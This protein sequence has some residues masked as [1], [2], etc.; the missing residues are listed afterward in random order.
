MTTSLS[1]LHVAVAVSFSSFLACSSFAQEGGIETVQDIVNQ[2]GVQGGL[3]VEVGAA[4]AKQTAALRLSERFLVQGLQKDAARVAAA[5][6]ELLDAGL[7][8]PVTVIHW[9]GGELPYADGVVNLLL[10]RD[11]EG[12]SPGEVIRV[13]APGGVANLRSGGSW[14]KQVEPRPETIDE[15]THFL[16]APD[17]NAV[18][19]DTEIEPPH[20]LQWTAGPRWGRSHDHLASMSAAVSAAGRLFYIMDEGPVASVKEPS[21]WALVA[22]DAMSGVLLWKKEVGPWEDQLRPFRSGPAEMPRRLVAVG[23]RVYVTLG[24]GKPVTALHAATGEVIQTYAGTDNT[25]EILCSGGKLYLVVA[26]PLAERSGTTGRVIRTLSP[27]RGAYRRYVIQFPTKHLL[28]LEADTGKLVWKKQDADTVNVMPLTPAVSRGRLFFENERQLVALSADSG[29][30]LW[31]VDRPVALHRYAW[32]SPTVVVKDGVVLSADRSAEVPLGTTE[33]AVGVENPAPDAGGDKAE[34]EWLV[35]ANHLLTGGEIMAFSAETG[36]KLWTAPCHEGFNFP[37]EVFVVNGKV[38]SGEMAWG[39]QPGVTKVYDLHTGRVVAERPPDQQCYTIGFGHHRCYRNKATTRYLIHGRSGVEFLDLGSD[40]VVA[41]HWVRGTCQYGILPCNGLLYAPPHSCACY[42]TAKLNGFNA[43]APKR[44][45]DGRQRAEGSE[46]RALEKGPA[47]APTPNPQSPIPSPSDWLT[48]RHDAARSGVAGVSL[49]PELKRGWEKQ[50]AGPLSSVVVAGG[51]VFFAQTELHTVRA[52]SATDGSPLWQFTAGGRVDSPPTIYGGR[53][54]FGSADGWIYCLRATDGALAWRFRAAP[55]PRQVV[56]YEQL[57]SVWPLHGNVLVLPG[58]GESPSVVCAV[59]GLS[60][61]LDG[62][63]F[64]VRLDART[65]ELLSRR[66]ISSRDPKTGQEPQGTVRGVSMP[67]ALPDVLSTDGSSLFM[68]HARFDLE[69]NPQPENADHLFSSVGF[70]DGDWWHRTY[71]QIGT[72]MGTGYGGWPT[73]GNRRISGRLLVVAGERVFGFG[74]KAYSV[75]GAHVGLQAEHHLFSAETKLVQP[76]PPKG[77]APKGRRPRR[78]ATQVHHHWS[79]PLPFFARAMLLA[80][81]TLLVAGPSK[82][83]DV[84][85]EKPEGDV[86]LWAVSATDG[87]KRAEYGLKAS[88][89]FDGMAA[90]ADGL[91]FTTVDGR[92]VCYLPAG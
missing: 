42:I 68:R 21:R 47:F 91:F 13:L 88:P 51:T 53:V 23:D 39:R 36:E 48:Y 85:A 58:E 30:V 5:R 31:K 7:L 44:E 34:L 80:G 55:K 82:I 27:W 24:Y 33:A 54:Y 37:V 18:A 79:Q 26:D 3:L 87:A 92:V 77:Q 19:D 71:W 84:E 9:P 67:G 69:G 17:N 4:D 66:R 32:S 50:F 12:V 1:R 43:L 81:D 57:E 86:R 8:G 35:T 20:H 61:F 10:V 62:G 70:L 41:D 14:K 59:A 16:H 45:E 74:R 83:V 25:H 38:Y 63:L 2:S 40:R 22:R 89:V 76:Q 15:W 49:S 65:G 6:R 28:C 73:V 11:A 78:P 64:L 46:Q 56:A 29:E 75:T 72:T 52:V 60:S 90:T